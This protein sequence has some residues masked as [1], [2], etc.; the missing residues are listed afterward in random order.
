MTATEAQVRLATKLYDMR[1][2]ARLLLGERYKP[3][4]AEFGSAIRARAKASGKDALN[5]TLAMCKECE[6]D[7][8]TAGNERSEL[9]ICY[10]CA[11][12]VEMTEPTP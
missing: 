3:V 8:V 10:L 2:R 11:A 1:E 5:V 6:R 7:A 9:A 12:F 4:M